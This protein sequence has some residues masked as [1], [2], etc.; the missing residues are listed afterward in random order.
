METPRTEIRLTRLAPWF[1]CLA[2][3]LSACDRS[4]YSPSSDDPATTYMEAC[5]P[6][7]QGGS[8][9]ASLAGRKLTPEAV[10][11]RLDRGGKGMPAFPGIRGGSRKQLVGFVVRMSGG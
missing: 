2:A 9:G 1:L 6:C 4:P 5:F 10:S 8:A 3:L 11:E 7:H